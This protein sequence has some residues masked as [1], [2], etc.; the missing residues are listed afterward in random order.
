MTRPV[1]SILIVEDE[2][3]VAVDIE[4]HLQRLGYHVAG[5]AG[6]AEEACQMAARLQP[7]LVLM[8]V[9]IEGPIDGIEAARQIRRRREIPVVFLT[10]RAQPVDLCRGYSS[11]AAAYI[12][13][14]FGVH[15]LVD[16]VHRVVDLSGRGVCVTPDLVQEV[17]V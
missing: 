14:P 1:A 3:I 4:D 16:L 11:G 6:S 2:Q 10:A 13:K 5:T 8:D 9:R 7:D 15:A 12:T 17:A